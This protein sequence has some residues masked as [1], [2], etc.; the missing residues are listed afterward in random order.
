DT[1]VRLTDQQASLVNKYREQWLKKATGEPGDPR[2]FSEAF[3]KITENPFLLNVVENTLAQGE[4]AGRQEVSL[5]RGKDNDASHLR[6]AFVER[7]PVL[8]SG[9]N[10]LW[11]T[12]YQPLTQEH[13]AHR[14]SNLS[15][16]HK[17]R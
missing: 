11:R 7:Y 9:L 17:A 5:W 8:Q 13:I 15:P 2:A 14:L 16:E 1:A 3:S 6:A 4:V 12:Q 10:N